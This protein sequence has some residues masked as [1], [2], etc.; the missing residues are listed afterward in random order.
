M[1]TMKIDF[2]IWRTGDTL[3]FHDWSCYDSPRLVLYH[4]I[5]NLHIP[6]TWYRVNNFL[7]ELNFLHR[8]MVE[9]ENERGE[10]NMIIS[11][12]GIPESDQSLYAPM[13][14]L[15]GGFEPI[16]NSTDLIRWAAGKLKVKSPV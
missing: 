15:S 14:L 1:T 9:L 6:V 12:F 13:V 7:G 8:A 3:S 2:S 16:G 4:D 10:V 11:L 5:T